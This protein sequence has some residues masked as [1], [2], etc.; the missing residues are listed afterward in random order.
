MRPG[1]LLRGRDVVGQR[2]LVA[3]NAL[4]ADHA[5]VATD[6]V[7]HHA[8]MDGRHTQ[9]GRLQGERRTRGETEVRE[10]PV[11]DTCSVRSSQ[12]EERHNEGKEKIGPRDSE[13]LRQTTAQ[14]HMWPIKFFDP[15]RQP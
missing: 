13:Y 14:W 4:A 12:A 6:G 2:G 8:G 15:A 5:D 11:T 9:W 3:R 7:G 10:L 1:L